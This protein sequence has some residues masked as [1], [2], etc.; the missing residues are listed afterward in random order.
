MEEPLSGSPWLTPISSVMTS[1]H[2]KDS[3]TIRPHPRRLGSPLVCVSVYFNCRS[4]ESNKDIVTLNYCTK[5]LR[6]R[7]GYGFKACQ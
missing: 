5:Q 7:D 3:L 1:C 4:R 2:T 6:E